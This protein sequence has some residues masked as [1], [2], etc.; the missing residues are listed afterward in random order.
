MTTSTPSAGGETRP[1]RRERTRRQPS[2]PAVIGADRAR[3]IAR[4]LSEGA[5]LAPVT[6]GILQLA[7][8]DRA[9]VDTTVW[10]RI[11]AG[12]LVEIVLDVNDRRALWVL[13]VT[14]EHPAPATA[15]RL[16]RKFDREG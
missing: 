16:V 3:E 10:A 4:S 1:R 2:W 13:A 5:A 14:G 6:A 12:E 8:E 9:P 11:D 7:V 15:G